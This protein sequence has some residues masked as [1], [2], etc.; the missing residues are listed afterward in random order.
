[1]K[2]RNHSNSGQVVKWS[3]RQVT[4]HSI[5]RTLVHS[6][7]L[8]FCLLS[9]PLSAQYLITTPDSLMDNTADYLVITHGTFTDAVYPLCRLR[10]SLGL[11]VKMAEVGL[12]YST[13]NT[14]P[15]TD[16]I[17]A[18]MHQVY[19][20]WTSRPA[21]VVLVGDASKDSTTG[22]DFVPVKLFPK[23]SY[24][25]YGGLTVHSIDNWYAQLEGQ[26]S[27]PDVIIG[28]LPVNS[29]ARCESLV[30][31]IVRYET[32]PDTGAWIHRALLTSSNDRDEWAVH[33]DTLFLHPN[34][35][36]VYRVHESDGN[37]AFLRQKMR[38]GFNLGVAMVGAVTHG[39]QPPVW[40]GS[41]T[42]FSYQDVDSLRNINALPV[43]LGRG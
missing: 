40:L 29:A 32:A 39:S 15:R 41:K 31:K 34:Y 37:T 21:Y 3:S 27:I 36:S 35:D 42:I 4:G 25:Y 33:M 30:S 18:F 43:V 19:D 16:R 7:A 14:G 17:K 26:D 8:L 6:I 12:I 28:R 13:F 22:Q 20:H 2:E 24:S 23:F 10:E 11:E 38:A 5:T 1:M 9:A